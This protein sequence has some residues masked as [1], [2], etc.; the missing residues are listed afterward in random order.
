MPENITG[1][2]LSVETESM[3]FS[4]F[5]VKVRYVGALS[6]PWIKRRVFSIVLCMRDISNSSI[7]AGIS[8]TAISHT[9]GIYCKGVFHCWI[10]KK[11]FYSLDLVKSVILYREMINKLQNYLLVQCLLFFLYISRLIKNEY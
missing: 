4:S 1:G 2:I 10:F 7:K 3:T 11:N 5:G 6:N 9:C 8:V